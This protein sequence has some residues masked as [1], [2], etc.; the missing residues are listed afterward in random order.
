MLSTYSLFV[1]VKKFTKIFS[2]G[3]SGSFEFT[4]TTL[5]TLRKDTIPNLSPIPDLTKEQ[6]PDP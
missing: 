5:D 3:E 2:Q 6:D 1:A 4:F